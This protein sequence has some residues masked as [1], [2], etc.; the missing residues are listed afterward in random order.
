[1]KVTI[2]QLAA[3]P[4]RR[5]FD[6]AAIGCWLGAVALGAGGC[7][8]GAYMPCTQPVAVT[9]RML[10]WGFYLGG[11]GASIG[12]LLGTWM[13]RTPRSPPQGPGGAGKAP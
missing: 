1:M 12:A 8:L 2:N 3:N 5:R 10:W 7:L 11:F 4:I 13:A 6:P 9:A